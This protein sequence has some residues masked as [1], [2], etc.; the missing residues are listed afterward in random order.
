MATDFAT[1]YAAIIKQEKQEDGTLLVYGK[2]TDDSLD[3]DKQICDNTWLSSAM[4]E[5]FKSGG[6]IREQHSHIAAG[7]AKELDSKEDGYYISALVVDPTSVK[8]VETGVLKGF[9][10]GIRSPRIIRDEKAANG[11][12]IDGQIVEVSLVDRPANP[13]A[14]LMLA[15][16]DGTEVI[17]VEEMIEQE[18]PVETVVTEEVI[19]TEA[20]IDDAIKTSEIEEPAVEETEV[21]A[22]ETVIEEA[23]KTVT[24]TQ[25][26]ALAKDIEVP[27]NKFDAATF[28]NARAALA[29]LIQ[30]E[31]KELEQG[32][33]EAYSL[34][35][36]LNAV[37]SLMSWYE[38]EKAE[39]EVTEMETVELADKAE[40]EKSVTTIVPEPILERLPSVS[41]D[42]VFESVED[43]SKS[44]LTD[45]AISDII[46]K[47]VK[48][49]TENVI[50]EIEVI[51]SASE[52]DK[53]T[54]SKLQDDLATANNKA[55]QGGPK[56]A[57]LTTEGNSI[58]EFLLM[59]M[60]YR[61]KA[62]NATD[63]LLARGYKELAS[64]YEAK[65]KTTIK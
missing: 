26:I 42:D 63:P 9:S 19:A 21:V 30:I 1:S 2:A 44:A 51:K 43:S 50:K 11:R 64:E 25:I 7:V 36:L 56:R 38:G 34:S 32:E 3:I 5:W 54:I 4:P 59:A 31:A 55:A 10:I 8:K 53:T 16:S 40:T 48:S 28:N 35:C 14:K 23:V 6:N 13:N 37:Y 27:V 41:D 60:E 47:A 22:E 29:Q 45:T 57:K 58:N 46:E 18:L 49:A 24:A 33:D 20:V 15:K 17:Q 62:A 61:T 12:I 52:A 39:G 65:S